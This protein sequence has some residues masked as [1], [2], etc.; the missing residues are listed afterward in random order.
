MRAAIIALMLMIGSQAWAE[1]GKL[2][3]YDWWSTATEA[4]VQAELDAGADVMARNEDGGTPL[5]YAAMNGN[6]EV[7][8][9][10]LELGADI[11]AKD[12]DGYTPLHWASRRGHAE[13][14]KLLLEHGADHAGDRDHR[15]QRD[16]EAHRRD[17]LDG[18]AQ[19]AV[20]GLQ[21]QARSGS[22]RHGR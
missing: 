10:L 1:C 2:C 9:R 5:H 7:V 19:Q 21:A 22:G 4:D 14:V 16:R 3:D 11:N 15:Q 18:I 6:P 17:Q 8:E 20:G 12:N 13:A